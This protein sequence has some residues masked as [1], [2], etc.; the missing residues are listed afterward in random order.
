M[1]NE[2]SSI[3]IIVNAKKKKIYIIHI[4]EYSAHLTRPDLSNK[5]WFT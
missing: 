4:E 3:K 1:I 5:K 2:R